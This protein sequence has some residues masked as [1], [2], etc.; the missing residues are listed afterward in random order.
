MLALLTGRDYVAD[1]HLGM[2]HQPN[3]ADAL[4]VRKPSFAPAADGKILDE[5][6]LPLATDRVRYVGEAVAIVVAETL[7]AARDAAEAVAVEYQ[8]LPAAT[9]VLAALADGAPQVWPDAPKNLALDNAFGDRVAV[10]AAMAQAHLVVK[11]T[12]RSQRTASAFMEPR[13]AIMMRAKTSTP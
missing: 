10:E 12:I 1:G 7:S 9:D 13:S 5:R 4:D 8:V 2:S 6:Q 3:P 11:Q